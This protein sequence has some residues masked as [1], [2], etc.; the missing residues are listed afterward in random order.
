MTLYRVP[1]GLHGGR[2]GEPVVDILVA[3]GVLVPVEPCEHG[4]TGRHIIKGT[5]T[6]AHDGSILWGECPGA[7]VDE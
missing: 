7:G 6:V 2:S 4:N 3:N 1:D 5:V